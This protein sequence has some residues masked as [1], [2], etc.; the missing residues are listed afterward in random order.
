M[1]IPPIRLKKYF[2]FLYAG[3]LN[4]S[5]I[6]NFPTFPLTWSFFVTSHVSLSQGF[7]SK[8]GGHFSPPSD[9]AAN[10]TA[11]GVMLGPLRQ[12]SIWEVPGNDVMRP[13]WPTFYR[14]GRVGFGWVVV[15]PPGFLGAGEKKHFRVKHR[16]Q[17]VGMGWESSTKKCT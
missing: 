14:S 12:Y 2:S 17:R 1:F 6:P 8:N 10:L 15:F 13:L 11:P 3:S 16:N 7:S 9:F 5:E 4:I